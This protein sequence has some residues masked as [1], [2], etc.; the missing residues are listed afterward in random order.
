MVHISQRAQ[1]GRIPRFQRHV[2]SAWGPGESSAL[3][4]GIKQTSER[5]G[6]REIEGKRKCTYGEG[7]SSNGEVKTRDQKCNL[8][9]LLTWV[10]F[11]LLS[12]VDLCNYVSVNGATAHPHIESDGT[13]YNIGNCF[14]KN[15][16][17]AYNIV[18]IPP[19]QAGQFTNLI[20]LKTNIYIV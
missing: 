18:K 16:S 7:A 8:I 15:F 5:V 6:P 1:S 4:M 19:L 9:F 3:K 2:G 10:T 14:G 20:L 11:T 12:Q 17:I 13:V